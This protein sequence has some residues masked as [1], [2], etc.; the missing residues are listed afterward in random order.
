YAVKGITIE[1][2]KGAEKES[3]QTST[4][5]TPP[6]SSSTTTLTD[7][8]DPT[9]LTTLTD[10]IAPRT[11]APKPTEL[12]IE[13]PCTGSTL[14]SMT[15]WSSLTSL[16]YGLMYFM[17]FG[18]QITG[19]LIIS[20][21]QQITV[22][23]MGKT[24]D[25]AALINSLLG[26][27]NLLGRLAV[28]VLSDVIGSRKT[29]FVVSTGVQGLLLGVLPTVIWRQS[30]A[31]FLVCVN[32][33]AFFYGAGFGII[34]AFLADQFGSRNVGATHGVIL[35]AWSVAGVCGGIVFTAV[36]NSELRRVYDAVTK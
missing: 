7:G 15:L 25:E 4:T 17:F 1:T 21:I 36:Y 28:P 8:I 9:T 30:F 5:P 2:I 19:L 20:K 29:L 10:R 31:G 11:A 22:T 6:P 24:T 18:A 32:V 26:G 14:F 34:P 16:E 3:F 23:Q 13:E 27:A 12:T 35:T 33:V